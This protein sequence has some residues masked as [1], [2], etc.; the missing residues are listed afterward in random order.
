MVAILPQV[1][2]IIAGIPVPNTA[3]INASIA[4]T[5]ANLPDQGYNH[6]MRS[7]L[8]GQAIINKLPAANRSE[9][10]QE[11]FGVAVILHDLGWSNNPE[12]IS[13]D[14]RFEVDGAIAARSFVQHEGG[15]KWDKHRQ[16]LV[17]NSIA[18]HATPGIAR[19]KEPEV[20]IVSAGTYTELLGPELAKQVYGDF[21]TVNQTEWEQIAN[22]FPR[23]GLNSYIRGIFT[24]FC[25]FKP[26][27]TYDN[28]VGDYGEVFLKNY[29]RVGHGVVDLL[30]PE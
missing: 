19:Y 20:A 14:R 22:E 13:S 9:I 27:T 7:W 26:N 23:R 8:N 12:I 24:G 21:I 15:G 3:L 29:T 1:T 16:Q 30:I 25:I 2:R 4:L 28:L 17:W 5:R 10:D 11:A 18:V 6:I